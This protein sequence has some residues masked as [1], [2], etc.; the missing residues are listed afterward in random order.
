[1]TAAGTIIPLEPDAVVTRSDK[2]PNAV[3][4]SGAKGFSAITRRE[5]IRDGKSV[6]QLLSKDVYPPPSR[7]LSGTRPWECET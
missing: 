4:Q 6:E 7:I 2:G 1:M 5:I 3:V